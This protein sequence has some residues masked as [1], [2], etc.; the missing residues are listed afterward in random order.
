MGRLQRFV[1][2]AVQAVREGGGG[3]GVGAMRDELL[4]APVQ[5]GKTVVLF[6]EGGGENRTGKQ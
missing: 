5:N 4:L 2:P 1:K 3:G 6:A